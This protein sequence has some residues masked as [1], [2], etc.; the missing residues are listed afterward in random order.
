MGQD[1]QK[2]VDE[3]KKE[4]RK[5]SVWRRIVLGLAC[6]VVFCTTYAL[7]LPAI[8][9][10]QDTFCGKEEHTHTQECYVRDPMAAVL[11]CP[12]EE[13]AYVLA[14]GTV[15][16]E[17]PTEVEATA[18]PA[19]E[20]TET[21][22]AEATEVPAIEVT[23]APVAEEPEIPT[24]EIPEEPVV[25][26]TEVTTP[27]PTEAPTPE[28][29]AVPTEAPTA[30]PVPTPHVHTA[31][32]YAY[33]AEDELTCT[34]EEGEG[35]THNFLCYGSWKLAC[36]KEEHAHSLACFSNPQA[37][38]ES[39][40]VWEQMMN[41]LSLTGDW[42]ED[43][44][45][46]AKNQV[47]YGESTLNY[48]VSEGGAL[49]GY[50][51]YGAW[52]GTPYAD[53]NTLFANFCIS[54]AGVEGMP[55]AEDCFTWINELTAVNLYQ[56]AQDDT[57]E[58]GKLLFADSDG[59]GMA[60][61]VGIIMET[62]DATEEV[63]AQIKAIS[64]NI[65]DQVQ[66]VVY[67]SGDAQ[68]VG[69]G[70]LPKQPA[71][72]YQYVDSKVKVE[73]QLPEGTGVP[74]N[75]QLMVKTIGPESAEYAS[76]L[77][78][79]QAAIEGDIAQIQFYDISFYSKQNEYIPFEDWAQVTMNFGE[80]VVESVEE[81]VVLH[82]D[83]KESAPVVLED[84]SVAGEAVADDS[85]GVVYANTEPVTGT[86]VSFETN[87]F[88]TFA[89]VGVQIGNGPG[90]YELTVTSAPTSTAYI[91]DPRT[92]MIHTMTD[93]V[94]D[95]LDG[96]KDTRIAL[97]SEIVTIHENGVESQQLKGVEVI[98]EEGKIIATADERLLWNIAQITP[99]E[100]IY[101]QS[102]ATGQYL[103]VDDAGNWGLS[104]EKQACK[105]AAVFTNDNSNRVIFAEFNA[106]LALF[107]QAERPNDEGIPYFTTTTEQDT[108]HNRVLLT[109]YTENTQYVPDYTNYITN[110]DGQILM[111]IAVNNDI[112]PD[113][114]DQENRIYPALGSTLNS[115]GW[116]NYLVGSD[117]WS[118]SVNNGVLKIA[119]ENDLS[120]RLAWKF[121]SAGDP[122]EYYLQAY[123][124]YDETDTTYVTQNNNDVHDFPDNDNVGKYLNISSTGIFMSETP[125]AI[126]VLRA[127]IDGDCQV[128]QNVICLRAKVDDTYYYAQ[129]QSN[130]GNRD[131]TSSGV[132]DENANSTPNYRGNHFVLASL[133]EQADINFMD[134]I[135]E[136]PATEEFDAIVDAIT[137]ADAAETFALQTA[138]RKRL[139]QLAMQAAEYYFGTTEYTADSICVLSPVQMNFIGKDR[140]DKFLALEWLWR[141]DPNEVTAA[142]PDV[143]LKLFNYTEEINNHYFDV[144]DTK[145][146]S[147]YSYDSNEK[148]V[149]DNRT[150]NNGESWAPVMSPVLGENGYPVITR[151][152][153]QVTT[154]DSDTQ[155]TTTTT[156]WVD[157]SNGELDYLFNN[158]NATMQK[159][160]GLF[161]KDERGYYYYYSDMNAACYDKGAEKFTLYDV[162]VRPEYTR[163]TYKV[164]NSATNDSRSNFLPFDEVV[165]NIIYDDPPLY[166]LGEIE[167]DEFGDDPNIVT[168]RYD[169]GS[170][171][172]QTAYLNDPTDL[173]F[174]MSLDYN[175]FIP[176]DAQIVT[177]INGETFVEDMIFEFHGDDDVFVYIDDVLILDIGGAHAA[178]SGR[179]NFATGE[180]YY[181]TD[182][183]A[184]GDGV[185]E[186][187]VNPVN[188]NLEKLFTDALGEN[189]T[190]AFKD[191]TL[192]DSTM[193]NLKFFYV[194]RGGTYS[195]AGI[196]FNMPTVPENSLMVGK[197]LTN[198]DKVIDARLD[199]IYRIAN[200]DN[201]DESFL[202]PGTSFIIYE[203]GELADNPNGVVG[204]DGTFTLK[205][206]QRALFAGMLDPVSGP[207][208]FVVQEL[209]PTN[210]DGQYKVSYTDD[211]RSEIPI[212]T[213]T[214]KDGMKIYTSQ[215]YYSV[216][217]GDMNYTKNVI[218]T[219][220]VVEDKLDTLQITKEKG[221]DTEIDESQEFKIYVQV[222]NKQDGDLLPLPVGT[223]YKVGEVEHTIKE[224]G[225][226]PLK[227][228]DTA[229][230]IGFLSGT[231]W[232]IEERDSGNY[233]PIYSGW[234]KEGC[235]YGLGNEGTFGLADTVQFTVT[236]YASDVFLEIPITKEA[237]GNTSS[238]T[239]NFVVEEGT[240][241]NGV[242]NK[243][244]DKNGG[245]ITV[246]DDEVAEGKIVLDFK[247]T[248]E[249]SFYYKI[250]EDK[251]TGDFIYDET[252][253][254]V[255]V[256]LVDNGNG[257]KTAQVV[258]VL[259]NGKDEVNASLALPF[260]NQ[261]VTYLTVDKTVVNSTNPSDVG[262][263]FTF[264][265]TI[266]DA[267]GETVWPQEPDG[268][269]YT[270]VENSGIV[271][272]ALK[273][274]E[275]VTIPVPEGV[276]VTVTE[277]NGE[278]YTTSHQITYG[279]QDSGAIIS[280]ATTGEITVGA[281]VVKVHFINRTGYELPKTGG[282]GT[283][284][285]RLGG[286]LL[287]VVSVGLG[288]FR[289]RRKS[290]RN[291]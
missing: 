200:A 44:V 291:T 185:P 267:N 99:Q 59:D 240:W 272:F 193:H 197:D 135:D 70:S 222:A 216:D 164:A 194:E 112:A 273:H 88:S 22:V 275:E 31:E 25:E 12:L 50:T 238:Q 223:I 32:C 95:N 205:A 64:G 57:P 245:R 251:G 51:R 1:L 165:G 47:G 243:T 56:S 98:Y 198:T 81:M 169:N 209:I 127:T 282:S 67:E 232:I 65:E 249:G 106:Y 108:A 189:N 152:P 39:A 264:E 176:K 230:I 126:E 173:W 6:C 283:T 16:D 166:E 42:T 208:R 143:V 128:N 29:T 87:G 30:T 210:I 76:L 58:K 250:S 3:Y 133:A 100:T 139:R 206:N 160:G 41:S 61:R 233:M 255:K 248:D 131:F 72:T 79:A 199:Y 221:A 83:E 137:G 274:E 109:E 259:K 153:V 60:D 289:M 19:V 21:L 118:A 145:R 174:G 182:L 40:V 172:T 119:G 271:R 26:S 85:I 285:Y 229:T 33:P 288:I 213:P 82:Y 141:K 123:N 49:Y 177:E 260:V 125:Q 17:L 96:G 74:R 157:V 13:G 156:E 279:T 105:T 37:D 78:Q 161:Q 116:E 11:I 71:P 129:L 254:I 220:E 162:V 46:I 227:V 84:V 263:S 281:D 175:F 9:M 14:D 94:E 114:T 140:I 188:T 159:G 151:I 252:F 142:E 286:L 48:Q 226:I 203:D 2:N 110:L 186:E 202:A 147:F 138:E 130:Y 253:Y 234:S 93:A 224:P 34:L 77:A 63:P 115:S 90:T 10:K 196:K 265:V 256:D 184:N 247:S 134:W 183:D 190:V 104:T 148:T 192:A 239:F 219:N 55:F 268:S 66:C 36:T 52:N 235:I 122:G 8:T 7:I 215:P 201:P 261:K 121:E 113:V 284:P 144:G 242:W 24:E 181:E 75:A 68:I 23:E 38:V 258:Q 163:L 136:I 278:G 35:H 269:S 218:F 146:F 212:I 150:P 228:N 168:S 107:S 277:T 101:I 43:I 280:G 191:N 20:A 111:A 117:V 132:L 15:V 241:S 54:Y 124:Y 158:P 290:S 89:V 187:G 225:I 69:Y 204:A 266:V 257:E 170:T 73:V 246:K 97:S 91:V 149:D 92:F 53:W 195:Y 270:V 236:N 28:P 262:G 62:T 231:Y 155:E 214:E 27:E 80:G 18:V 45:V 211:S 171:E 4:N 102:V 207:D 180:V 287:M 178:R 86:V 244:K 120:N 154:T 179:I 5:H 276:T 103:Y 217:S 237:V 167:G